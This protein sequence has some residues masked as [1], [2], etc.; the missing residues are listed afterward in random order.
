MIGAGVVPPSKRIGSDVPASSRAAFS[1]PR[2][3]RTSL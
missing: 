1:A 3:A 2:D